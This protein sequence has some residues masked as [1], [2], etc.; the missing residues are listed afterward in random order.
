MRLG[1]VPDRLRTSSSATLVTRP[2]SC[3]SG[4]HEELAV[5]LAVLDDL[6]QHDLIPRHVDDEQVVA[7]GA[8]IGVE[9]P[10]R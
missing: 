10:V 8:F 1:E 5:W 4:W 2:G 6:V 3:C 7:E 9:G